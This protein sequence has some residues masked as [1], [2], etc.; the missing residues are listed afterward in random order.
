MSTGDPNTE[1]S[2]GSGDPDEPEVTANYP[3]GEA[4]QAAGRESEVEGAL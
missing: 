4:K 2:V 3:A 1:A